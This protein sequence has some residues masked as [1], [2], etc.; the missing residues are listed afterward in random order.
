MQTAIE[1]FDDI[2]NEMPESEAAFSV[3]KDAL[4]SR[5]RTNRTI[6]IDVL[7]SYVA[8]RRLSLDKPLDEQMFNEI[9]GMTLK[10]V[11]A[12]QEEWVKG[13]N[14]TFAILGDIKDLDMDYLKT[15]G[16]V[17]VV[18]TNEIFGY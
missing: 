4:T 1:A 8:C 13:R 6:G 17:K 10:D 11:K 5:L 18:S 7:R 14:Y 2:I 12:F 3:A 15:L 16:P 9:Q